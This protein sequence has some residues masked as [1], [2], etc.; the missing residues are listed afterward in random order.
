MSN[1]SD[2]SQTS[3]F[4]RDNIVKI[5][6]KNGDFFGT[7][8]CLEFNQKKYFITCHHCICNLDQIFREKW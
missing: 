2:S 3:G 8:F 5:V 4:V 1:G 6:N 7:G